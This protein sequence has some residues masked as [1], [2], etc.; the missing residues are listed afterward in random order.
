[1]VTRPRHQA[2]DLVRP[3]KALGAATAVMPAI[4]IVP[5]E[6][7][8]PL[9]AALANLDRYDWVVLTSVNGVMATVE[10][11]DH[12][13][14]SRER[15]AKRRLAAVGPATVMA[16][17]REV[18]APDAVP[19]E[20][21]GEALADAMGEVRGAQCLLA[22]ADRARKE[23]PEILHSRGAIVEDVV[24]YRIVRSAGAE[25]LPETAPDA[26]LLTSAESARATYE[27]LE[28]R[29]HGDWFARAS[30]VCIGR[31]TAAA[32]VELGYK[33]AAVAKEYTISGLVEALVSHV[34]NG[35]A[36]NA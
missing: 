30:L 25:G 22:R 4:E 23:L 29:G 2:G 12:L 10:R 27:T 31:I 5:P 32:V 24:A 14:I 17:V 6:D 26:I 36:A 11:M 21:V 13:G 3:L 1:M 28:R 8:A 20:Y 15:L 19:T 16:L 18:R 34:R 33:P 7:Y 9:D 35:E